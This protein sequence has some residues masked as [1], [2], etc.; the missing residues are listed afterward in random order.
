MNIEI[1][2]LT[3][4]LL[5]DWLY[6]FDHAPVADGNEWAG[7]YCMAPHWSMALQNEK[8]W[9][10]S[11]EGAVRNR[12]YAEEYIEKG[13]LQGYLAYDGEKVVGWCNANDKRAYDSIFFLLPWEDA[14]KDQKIKAIACFY[15]ASE[16]RVKGV[17]TRLLEKICKDAADEGYAYVEAYP[18]THNE[19]NA[20]TGPVS[21]YEK[22][23][24]TVHGTSDIATVF[25][26][27]L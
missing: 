17:A 5:E 1:R 12:K 18:F 10:Y 21:M 3:V 22:N 11:E 16:V 6:F 25:R 14:E 24:F 27:Y 4:D 9:E 20:L 15:I 7:C 8:E 13:I 2:K 26:K 19:N 23:G